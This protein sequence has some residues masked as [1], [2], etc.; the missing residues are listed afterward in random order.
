M[1]KWGIAAFCGLGLDAWTKNVAFFSL[2]PLTHKSIG[3]PFGGVPLFEWGPITASLNLVTNTG[4]AWGLFQGHETLL[5]FFRLLLL[6]GFV[7]YFFRSH[8]FQRLSLFLVA[9]GAVGNTLDYCLYRQVIDFFHFTFWGH[10]FPLFNFADVYI[11]LGAVGL[12]FLP[13]RVSSG[14]VVR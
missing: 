5:F 10:S 12:L 7:F 14:A 6:T 1:M 8:G 3:F 13:K 4:A 11:T 9:L 2:A